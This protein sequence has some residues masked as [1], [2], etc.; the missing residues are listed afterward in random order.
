M[1]YI[2][3]GQCIT[4]NGPDVRFTSHEIC[5]FCTG[6]GAG[7]TGSAPNAA[8]LIYDATNRKPLSRS[9]YPGSVYAHQG[10]LSPDRGTF[11]LGDEGDEDETGD[12]T[13]THAFDV[14]SQTLYV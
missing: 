11:F 12:R 7:Y 10:W 14:R 4:Y 5:F 6:D 1:G 8:V 3:D 2:H 13:K 9:G